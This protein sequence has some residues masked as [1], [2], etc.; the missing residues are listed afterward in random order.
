MITKATVIILMGVS[1]SGKTTIGQLLSKDFN[2]PFF[3]GDQFHPH[4]NIAK[5]SQGKPLTDE[6]REPWLQ[7][8]NKIILEHSTKKGA[9]IACS[10]LKQKYRD[11]LT[12]GC[13]NARF[14]Y[15]KGEKDLILTRMRSRTDHFMPSSLLDSQFAALE[16]PDDAFIV[17][18]MKTPAE[19][20]ERIK[21]LISQSNMP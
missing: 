3:D 9:I 18:I 15:L 8:L 17:P 14:F 12:E 7:A 1:G 16:E 20:C 11:K 21:S 2:V 4:S 6:D 19:V 13:N 5:M 10:A